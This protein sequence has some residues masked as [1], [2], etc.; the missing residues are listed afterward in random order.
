MKSTLILIY[1]VFIV[2][3]GWLL[4]LQIRMSNDIHFIRQHL[5]DKIKTNSKAHTETICTEPRVDN[6]MPSPTKSDLMEFLD[7]IKKYKK[8]NKKVDAE[9]LDNLI[10]DYNSRFNEDFHQY[11]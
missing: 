7:K 8:E 4:W 6:G 9:W 11:I 1:I 10:Q 2:F 5:E 3:C